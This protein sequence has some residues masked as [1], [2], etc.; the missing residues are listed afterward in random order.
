[1]DKLFFSVLDE[2]RSIRAYKKKDVEKE[3]LDRILTA[4][5]SA[6]SAGNLQAYEIVLVKE[7]K[8]KEALAAASLSHDFIAEAPVVLVFCANQERSAV[9][10]GRR[11]H[12]LYSIQDATIAA[13][14]AQLAATALGLGSVWVGAFDE[15][16]IRKIINADKPV[17]I[18]P[19]GYPDEKPYKT[20]RRSL[21]D[22]THKDRIR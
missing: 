3:K 21:D 22:I 14:Y 18:I 2:R 1:M 20:G 17:A 9:R 7:K 16:S 13:S 11:G 12:D 6:P 5:N 8:T 10:Y 15:S 4:A 19:I